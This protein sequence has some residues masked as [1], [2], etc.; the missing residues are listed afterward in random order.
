VSRVAILCARGGSKGVPGKNTAMIAGK[1][2]I[3]WSILQALESGL[4]DHIA[5]SSDAPD[6]LDAAQ[7]A[8]ATLLVRRPDALAT[9]MVSVLP[10]IEHCLAAIEDD[11]S[12]KVDSFVFLQATSPTRG[13]TDIKDAVALFDAHGCTSVITGSAARASPY[14]S[15]VEETPQG[16][17]TLSK[18]TDPP[19]VR[20]Q[21]A[22]RCFAMNGSIY[23]V[24]RAGFGADQRMIWPDTRLF[25]M[26]EE[27]SVDI[28]TPLDLQIAEMIMAARHQLR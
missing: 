5:V 16:T 17:V 24:N 28:D 18:V 2:L 7:A 25:E 11:L 21:D 3:A 26:S 20:R 22:P 12:H 14:F 8:G 19:L 23:V 4:F 10:A 13:V 27:N 6:I 15:L 9:D 1:P